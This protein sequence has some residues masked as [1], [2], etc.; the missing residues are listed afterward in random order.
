MEKGFVAPVKNHGQR[1]IVKYLAHSQHRV[2]SLPSLNRASRRVAAA[3]ELSHV[4]SGRQPGAAA[5][6][7][8]PSTYPASAWRVASPPPASSSTTPSRRRRASLP[9]AR[10]GGGR[11]RGPGSSRGALER[12][13]A[14]LTAGRGCRSPEPPPSACLAPSLLFRDPSCRR[15]R[16]TERQRWRSSEGRHWDGGGARIQRRRTSSNERGSALRATSGDGGH[17][18][19]AKLWHGFEQR[20]KSQ[21]CDLEMMGSKNGE[22]CLP[23]SLFL[24]AFSSPLGRSE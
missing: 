24:G 8:P 13:Q 10:R 11:Q 18:S 21:E 19:Y 6:A 23:T 14:T 7:R 5:V 1:V 3:A 4:A 16:P 15:P 2:S 17:S 22:R 9:R 20:E 12:R